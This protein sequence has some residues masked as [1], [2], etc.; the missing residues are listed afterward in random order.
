[1]TANSY[2][3]FDSFCLANQHRLT[4]IAVHRFGLEVI[5]SLREYV[6]QL[7]IDFAAKRKKQIVAQEDEHIVL[8]WRLAC[9]AFVAKR[10]PETSIEVAFARALI[11][12]LFPIADAPEPIL[13]I[14]DFLMFMEMTG[15]FEST[16]MSLRYLLLEE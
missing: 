7:L 4:R 10:E 5:L 15:D 2:S 3:E 16:L 14:D 8:S 1:M 9:W 13:L 11:C 6:P 12:F